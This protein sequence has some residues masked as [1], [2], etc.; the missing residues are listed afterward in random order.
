[1]STLWQMIVMKKKDDY[2]DL[3]VKF[4]HP[5]AGPFPQDKNFALQLLISEA[6]DYEKNFQRIPNGSL[7]R[8]IPHEKYLPDDLEELVDTYIKDV[9]IYKAENLPWDE[10]EAHEKMDTLC[11]EDGLDE[12]HE[13]WDYTWQEHWRA[14]WQD[15]NR[16]PWAIYR[17]TMTDPKWADHLK[18]YQEFDSAGFST[19]SDYVNENVKIEVPDPSDISDY[20]S[21]ERKR[22]EDTLDE[23]V[24]KTEDPVTKKSLRNLWK[25]IVGSKK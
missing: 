19:G 3:L 6:Y 12:D 7:G 22:W 18:K 13:D 15:Y 21:T 14:F 4:D 5:D 23:I 25:I 8:A 10:T 1:M 17:I 11:I 20:L 24:E 2:I 9:L 16:I